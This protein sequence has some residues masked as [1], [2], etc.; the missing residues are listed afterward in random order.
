MGSVSIAGIPRWPDEPTHEVTAFVLPHAMID[1]A[2]LAELLRERTRFHRA[3]EVST[4][5]RAGRLDI[6]ASHGDGWMVQVSIQEGADV[7]ADSR[8]MAARSYADH[9]RATEMAACARRIGRPNQRSD[10]ARE[11]RPS[12]VPARHVI[13]RMCVVGVESRWPTVIEGAKGEVAETPSGI[14]I[15][16]STCR[17][18][19]P[20]TTF[21]DNRRKP[22]IKH[23]D[24]H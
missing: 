12:A 6:V 5:T 14:R 7:L 3:G 13:G 11:S 1:L 9:P 17:G 10:D 4:H 18:R 23:V 21:K 20:V 16:L 8:D 15:V 24:A 22:Q 19:K 2:P